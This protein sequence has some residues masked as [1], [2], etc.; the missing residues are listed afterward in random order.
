MHWNYGMIFKKIRTSKGLRQSEIT[1]GNLSPTTLSRLENGKLVPSVDTFQYLLEQ[2][3]ISYDEFEYISNNYFPNEKH[4]IMNNFFK[5]MSNASTD[6]LLKLRQRCET[7]LASREDTFLDSI[8]IVLDSALTLQ[9]DSHR[10]VDCLPKIMVSKIWV[11]LEKMDEWYLN[12]IRLLNAMLFFLPLETLKELVPRIILN[13]EKY[14]DFKPIEN[15][16]ISIFLNLSTLFLQNSDIASCL[17]TIL[18]AKNWAKQA[19]RYDYFAV[20]LIREGICDKDIDNIERGK[21][22]LLLIEAVELKTMLEKEIELF[23]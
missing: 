5:L 9:N 2:L 7:Y 1:G 23:F 17:K 21:Q 10:K 6:E 18:I 12:E 11:T 15:L 14:N 16:K 4:A 3:G 22:L 20:C 19:C 13:L 8:L